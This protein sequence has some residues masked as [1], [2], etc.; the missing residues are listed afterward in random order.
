ML[1]KGDVFQRSVDQQIAISQARTPSERFE[2][3]CE[4]LDAAR[5]M[6][7]A[8]AE[9]EDRRRMANAARQLD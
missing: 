2:A 8:G 4:L 9:A 1:P 5:A 3:L 7:P 6:A